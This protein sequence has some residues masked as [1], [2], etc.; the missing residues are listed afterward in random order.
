MRPL[1]NELIRSPGNS[2]AQNI[3]S[4]TSPEFTP[5]GSKSGNGF[6]E[7]VYSSTNMSPVLNFSD[8]YTDRLE[9]IRNG[10]NLKTANGINGSPRR[11][12]SNTHTLHRV[13]G[14]ANHN[15][16]YNRADDSVLNSSSVASSVWEDDNAEHQRPFTE[17]NRHSRISKLFG[18][19]GISKGTQIIPDFVSDSH[20]ENRDINI[21]SNM[22]RSQSDLVK[23]L[24]S[25]NTNL[26]V[27][28]LTLR[29]NLTGL[30][31]NS[32]EL[33][34]QNVALNQ[35]IIKLKEIID[36]NPKGIDTEG[37]I[38]T[39]EERYEE[40]LDRLRTDNQYLVGENEQVKHERDGLYREI[41]KL[42]AKCSNYEDEL[43]ELRLELDH[44]KENHVDDAH[45]AR[46]ISQLEEENAELE[47]HIDDLT[48]ENKDLS[49]DIYRLESELEEA[50][51]NLD[52]HDMS[53]EKVPGNNFSDEEESN[54]RLKELEAE[55]ALLK[56]KYDE[57]KRVNYRMSRDKVE[58]MTKRLEEAS[59]TIDSLEKEL[60][61]KESEALLFTRNIKEL[62][63]KLQSYQRKNESLE[64]RV[65]KLKGNQ[66]EATK[67]L[68]DEVT[69]LYSRIDDY[70][71]QL[72]QLQQTLEGYRNKEGD[73]KESYVSDLE[74]DK[75]KLYESLVES[76]KLIQRKEDEISSLKLDFS[77]LLKSSNEGYNG[78]SNKNITSN[79]EETVS[80]DDLIQ[81]KE[82]FEEERENHKH[83]V[84]NL[85]TDHQNINDK[86][87]A[88]IDEL[89]DSK[90]KLVQDFEN[91]HFQYRDLETLYNNI[92]NSKEVDDLSD[93]LAK[94]TLE[95][96]NS[97]AE[98][99]LLSDKYYQL[100]ELIRKKD[101]E[102]YSLRQE[103][104]S[105]VLQSVN[106]NRLDEKLSELEKSINTLKA[107]REKLESEKLSTEDENFQLKNSMERL[108]RKIK[109][110]EE[111]ITHLRSSEK[112]NSSLKLQLREKKLEIVQLEKR[113][114]S[115]DDEKIRLE[116][117]INS[118]S[119][120]QDKIL[121]RSDKIS[122]TI[123]TK[124][125]SNDFKVQEFEK[126]LEEKNNQYNDVV[127][128]YN[129][130]KNDLIERLKEMKSEIRNQGKDSKDE[131]AKW[132]TK[133]EQ[134]NSKLKVSERYL[135]VLKNDIKSLNEELEREKER[136]SIERDTRLDW[137]PPTP[138]SPSRMTGSNK[139]DTLK[140]QKDLLMLKVQEKS[141]KIS[142][143]R[144]MLK[145]VQLELDL[146]NEMF[147]KNKIL[148]LNAGIQA[149]PKSEKKA[150][151]SFRVVALTI[152][153]GVRF[154]N[155][156]KELQNRK[157]LE[158]ELKQEIKARKN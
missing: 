96:K 35:Q 21:D 25:Q 46:K 135:Q 34:E 73:I 97:Q 59:K 13:N 88:K 63:L 50:N 79:D 131:I 145:Y 142:D 103:L 30:P 114:R 110:N 132:K 138:E 48:K 27:E 12:T 1:N 118:V 5:I 129:Y 109:S 120:E 99:S 150:T 53:N 149:T 111:V 61:N 127:K 54:V 133:Y 137:F 71:E 98:Y 45:S 86:L 78:E 15:A 6:V 39:L 66:S 146:K 116:N 87:L 106:T 139:L 22:L 26:K 101:S 83:E 56:K 31:V 37:K 95:Y 107:Q 72:E 104:D 10:N 52:K 140:A 8:K 144:Y 76:Q 154:K 119:D 17:T 29:Q 108:N 152:L 67:L 70:E 155:R 57:D 134:S 74:D 32:I 102:I 4:N 105:Q 20:D 55:N 33:I 100:E 81:L 60:D 19:E 44:V 151:L 24:Q 47:R 130:M 40:D 58:E 82:K 84:E 11:S 128:E 18:R 113:I 123:R 38:E 158:R 16:E 80:I 51:R 68:T 14:T 62:N 2:R 121:A 153:A 92:I 122:E 136:A 77:T 49:N 125:L 64:S 85:I 3:P 143:L 157:V 43:G 65:S 28:V 117:I 90:S 124:G 147:K 94:V 148:F 9:K 126:K 69:D 89:E 7:S 112:E 41:E 42:E 115:I 93:D 156:L 75:E 141:E 91:L 23:K 36:S